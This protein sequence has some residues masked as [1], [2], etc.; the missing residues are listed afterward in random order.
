MFF[1]TFLFAANSC[2][3]MAQ[4]MG[5]TGVLFKAAAILAGIG[6]IV[7]GHKSYKRDSITS[8]NYSNQI[9]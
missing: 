8:Y 2:F 4:S 6:A 5:A 9:R 3:A 1:F 7:G